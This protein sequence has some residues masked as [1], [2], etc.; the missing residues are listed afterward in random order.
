MGKTEKKL[1]LSERLT[2]AAGLITKGNVVA[3]VGCDHAYTS[4][5]LCREE[6]APRVIAMDVNRGPLAGAKQHIEDAQLTER[7]EL[8]L[9]DGL[10]RLAPGE[11]DT[12]LLCG[13][14]GLL[15]RRILEEG[16]DAVK[17]AKELI[18]Q[19]QSEIA[20]VRRYL[21][22]EGYRIAAERML[23]EDGKFY[24][25]MRAVQAETPELYE[26]EEEYAY[27]RLLLKEKNEVLKEFLQRERYLKTEVL[28]TIEGQ[29]TQKARERMESLSYEF[30]LISNAERLMKEG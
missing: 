1:Q 13:M 22:K 6:I 3:D 28:H 5:Y 11:A 26:K 9:S 19:P 29:D 27:G 23:K 2:A 16:R 30:S 24:V 10:E 18:L 21:H 14:G 25:M 15:M 4:I 7:I 8:R 12:I 20:Q 17:A